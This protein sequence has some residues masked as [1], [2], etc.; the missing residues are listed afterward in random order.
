MKKIFCA[1]MMSAIL[2]FVTINFS[3]K[4]IFVFAEVGD[5]KKII[6][7]TDAKKNLSLKIK[8]IHSVQKTPVLEELVFDGENF[9]L[10]RTVYQSHGVGL[11]FLESDGTFR[12]EDGKFIF[13]NMNRKIESLE[14][15]TGKGTE[16]CIELDKKVFELYKIF[17]AG[18]K[19][20]VR[21]Q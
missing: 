20:V 9:I 15:R 8:F 10:L 11:P 4:K 6:T 13:E 21:E 12:E 2:L 14:L 16:L 5:A 3:A 19:I 7:V 1:L 17:P 18:T